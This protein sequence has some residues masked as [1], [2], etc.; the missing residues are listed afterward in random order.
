MS[1]AKNLYLHPD[2]FKSEYDKS[3]ELGKPTSKLIDMFQLIAENSIKIINGGNQTDDAA[4]I[5]YAV[6]EAY[7]KWNKFDTNVSQNI[8]S[9]FTTVILNDM[10]K[11]WNDLNKR[12][13]STIS[14]D[15]IFA[16]KKD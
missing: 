2:D 4:C 7:F 11:H 12:R 5:N 1:T 16:N 9:F 8:F 3:L 10:R 15:V 6:T 13:E 14:I